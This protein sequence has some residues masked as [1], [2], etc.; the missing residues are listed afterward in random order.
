[1]LFTAIERLLHV[2]GVSSND[3]SCAVALKS[4][5]NG[6]DVQVKFIT[7]KTRVTPLKEVIYENIHRLELQAALLVR[8][9]SKFVLEEHDLKFDDCFYWTDSMALWY[10]IHSETRRYKQFVANRLHE[11]WELTQI[12]DW[13][14][15]LSHENV[16]YDGTRLGSADFVSSSRWFNGPEF[17]YED[18]LKWPAVTDKRIS[19]S[20]F[21]DWMETA[22]AGHVSLV[23]AFELPQVERFSNWRRLINATAWV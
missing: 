10:W 23:S 13:N 20:N 8:K 5:Q 7:A 14:R 2:F 11:I 9:L 21:E 15:L 6:N 4:I 1:M 16:A 18:Q 12:E 22:R 17:L 19:P 3:A